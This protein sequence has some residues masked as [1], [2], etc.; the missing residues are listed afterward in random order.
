VNLLDL[1]ILLF[2]AALALLGAA[3][4]LIRLLLAGAALGAAWWLATRFHQPLGER[5]FGATDG[6]W[7]LAAFLLVL[8]LAA[9]A[10]LVVARLIAGVVRATPLRWVDRVLGGLS[11]LIIATVLAAAFL[12]P[13]QA[14]LSPSHP[15]LAG[16]ALAPYLMRIA[17]FLEPLVPEGVRE[18]LDSPGRLVAI[19]S[20]WAR[21]AAAAGGPG[22]PSGKGSSR[23]PGESQ[24]CRNGAEEGAG[25]VQRAP[26]SALTPER[27]LR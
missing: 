9:A 22:S 4:G 23:G 26:V 10:A 21:L 24:N 1:I 20:A 2:A 11:G 13:L 18:A 7:G 17:T 14:A 5:F 27:M 8:F 16:S 25:K 19:P 12:L 15:L 3:R 6:A